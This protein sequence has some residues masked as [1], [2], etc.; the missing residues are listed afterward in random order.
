MTMRR[1]IGICLAMSC[2]GGGGGDAGT[3]GADAFLGPGIK[4]DA[5]LVAGE[6]YV[7]ELRGPYRGPDPCNAP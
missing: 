3:G 7:I 2:G 4:P 1:S 6:P 5:E